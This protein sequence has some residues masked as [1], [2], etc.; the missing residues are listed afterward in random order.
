LAH[1]GD[2]VNA[3]WGYYYLTGDEAYYLSESEVFSFYNTGIIE[4]NIKPEEERY[5]LSCNRHQGETKIKGKILLAFDDCIAINYFGFWL[6]GFF[7][8]N[9]RSIIDAIEFSFNNYEAIMNK[10]EIFDRNLK[11]D[12]ARYGEDYYLILCAALRQSIGAHKLVADYEGNILFLSKECLSTVDVSYPSLP[13]FLLYNPELV[14]GMLRPVFRFSRMPVWPYDFAP[15]DCGTYP[16]CCGQTYGLTSAKNKYLNDTFSIDWKKKETFPLI[17]QFP[18][19]MQIYDLDRQMPVEE[20]SNMLIM[21]LALLT[22]GKN[23]DFIKDNLDLL[24]KWAEYLVKEGIKPKKQLCT[25]DFAGHLEGNVNLSIKSILGIQ[26][27][28]VLLDK[29]GNKEEAVY[30]LNISKDYSRLW[31]E[32]FKDLESIPL[33]FSGEKGSF[34]LKY[35]LVIDKLFNFKLFNPRVINNEIE[36]YLLRM[37]KYGVPL[38]NRATYT[39]SDWMV[40]VAA[41]SDNL[42]VRKKFLGRIVKYLN[43]TP[44]RVP[45]SD[46]YDT[47]T[48]EKV[49]FQNRSVQGGLF[50][51]ML[52]DKQILKIN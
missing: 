8:K 27:F 11:T 47:I 7:F 29:L 15:H 52:I 23:S 12:I 44:N 45:F 37:N 3:D 14:E 9:G 48:G 28:G 19:G 42:D 13:L 35:N 39:K 26:A 20:S 4:P 16:Y 49:G 22:T 2:P 6:K 25:D 36:N 31:E 51:L 38:D 41:L 1:V 24:K 34:S 50:I 30:Y 40:W 43:N 10:L 21:S 32:E 33:S 46:W 18:K 5:L 17:Y